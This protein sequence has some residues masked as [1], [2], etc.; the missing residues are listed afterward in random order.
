M[1]LHVPIL[2]SLVMWL[3]VERGNHGGRPVAYPIFYDTFNGGVLRGSQPR[4]LY[5]GAGY[6]WF[7]SLAMLKLASQSSWKVD[8]GE[9]YRR[10]KEVVARFIFWSESFLGWETYK[11]QFVLLFNGW[12]ARGSTPSL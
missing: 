5:R 11:T 9:S 1:G 7:R 6:W 12:L 8:N 2:Y 3:A 4:K 10:G